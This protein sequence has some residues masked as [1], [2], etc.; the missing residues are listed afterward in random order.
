[1]SQQFNNG[2]YNVSSIHSG[3][4][5][6][7]RF[8]ILQY[9]KELKDKSRMPVEENKAESKVVQQ[10]NVPP[11]LNIGGAE[12]FCKKRL[13][14][15]A[16]NSRVNEVELEHQRLVSMNPILAHKYPAYSEYMEEALAEKSYKQNAR[17]NK[18]F[19]TNLQ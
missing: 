17:V 5:S 10:L 16:I 6:S 14:V 15:S 12:D 7:E 11:M 1:M 19:Q 18:I 13:D 9:Q 8:Q 3:Y 2:G 4:N